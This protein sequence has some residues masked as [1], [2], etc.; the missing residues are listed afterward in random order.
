MPKDILR[1]Y[2]DQGRKQRLFLKYWTI[3]RGTATA[4]TDKAI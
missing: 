1:T 2:S 4:T 3:K